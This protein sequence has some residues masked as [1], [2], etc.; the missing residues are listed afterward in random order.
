VSVAS[1]LWLAAAAATALGAL[2]MLLSLDTLSAAVTTTV[3]GRFPAEAAATRER[4]VALAELVL[5]G[6]SGVLAAA[7][8]IGAV[9]LRAGRGGARFW[10]V[11]LAVTAALHALLASGA[12][13][14]T[15]IGLLAMGVLLGVGATVTMLLPGTHRWFELKQR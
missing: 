5:V 1:G 10:L 12:A 8:A 6:G 9:A 15:A 2:L 13:S 14:A 7:T 11:V 3:D 4:V